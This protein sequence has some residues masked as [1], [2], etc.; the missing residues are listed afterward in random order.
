MDEKLRFDY[1]VIVKQPAEHW[2]SPSWATCNLSTSGSFV[3]V[4]ETDELVLCRAYVHF[5]ISGGS[6]PEARAVLDTISTV[7]V[8]PSR[9]KVSLFC[10]LPAHVASIYALLIGCG[11]AIKTYFAGLD[12]NRRHDLFRLFNQQNGALVGQCS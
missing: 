6:A 9:K 7:V 10:V 8:V 2:Y 3:R 12:R 5:E 4:Q 1:A 11:I